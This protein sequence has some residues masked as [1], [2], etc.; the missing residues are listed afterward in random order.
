MR[1]PKQAETVQTHGQTVNI[2]GIVHHKIS[3]TTAKFCNCSMKTDRDNMN[4][5]D[6]IPIKLY[7]QK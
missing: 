5:N 2:F 1:T 4:E 3:V 7:L 6:C